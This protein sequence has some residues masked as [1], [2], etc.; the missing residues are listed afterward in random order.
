MV[1]TEKLTYR[2]SD[3]LLREVRG[4]TLNVDPRGKNWIWSQSLKQNL[5]YRIEGR[6]NAIL[7]A[8]S[9][10]MTQLEYR[11][12]RIAELQKVADLAQAFAAEIQGSDSDS[13]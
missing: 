6:T 4:C 2:D 12:A 8:L 9:A 7:A 11:D 13:E 1:S 3:G 5:V 10:A